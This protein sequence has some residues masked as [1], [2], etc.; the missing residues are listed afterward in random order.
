M[1]EVSE[2]EGGGGGGDDKRTWLCVCVCIDRKSDCQP[3]CV[4]ISSPMAAFASACLC[5]E[6]CVSVCAFV[7]WVVTCGTKDGPAD[8]SKICTR[9]G[10]EEKIDLENEKMT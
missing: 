5:L 6:M 7:P 1:F 9:T 3:R 10:E 4:R 2:T 8:F